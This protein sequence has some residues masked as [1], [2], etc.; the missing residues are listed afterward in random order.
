M[1]ALDLEAERGKQGD[2]AGSLASVI[3]R[4]MRKA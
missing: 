3:V 4:R 1:C 2:Q